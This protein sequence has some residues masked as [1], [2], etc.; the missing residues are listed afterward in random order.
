MTDAL[1]EKWKSP[2]ITGEE[3]PRKPD[4]IAFNN[5][6]AALDLIHNHLSKHSKI[7]VHCDVDM[8]GIGCGYI[9]K[10]LHIPRWT[11]LFY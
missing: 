4:M 11:G 9:I 1:L 6:V 7:A 2:V 10:K 5:T 8:D 3:H